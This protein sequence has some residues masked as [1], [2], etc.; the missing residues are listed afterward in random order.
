M[1]LSKTTINDKIEV[2]QMLGGYPVIQ[3]RKA[4]I[5]AEDCVEISRT[6]SRHVVTP[7]SDL[8]EEDADVVR[9]ADAVFTKEAKV[10]YSASLAA[11]E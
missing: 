3:I 10:S 1:A 9:I 8:S 5:I 2:L 11:E 6:F 7:S 4:S